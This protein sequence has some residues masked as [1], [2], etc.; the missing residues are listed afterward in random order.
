MSMLPPILHSTPKTRSPGPSNE[1]QKRQREVDGRV[2]GDADVDGNAVF[3]VFRAFDE[4]IEAAEPVI[5]QPF[6]DDVVG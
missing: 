2:G 5:G 1:E 3:R 4:M 6:F